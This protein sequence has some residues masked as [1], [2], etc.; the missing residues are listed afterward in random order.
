MMYLIMLGALVAAL[1][2]AY[3]KG[4]ADGAGGQKATDDA[5]IATAQAKVATT[6]A[7]NETLKADLTGI[8]TA[9]GKCSASVDAIAKAQAGIGPAVTVAIKASEARSRE[10][11]VDIAARAAATASASS[12]TPEQRCA[13]AQRILGDLSDRLHDREPPPTPAITEVPHA[14]APAAVTAP[15]TKPLPSAIRRPK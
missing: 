6:E 10:L 3:G 7:A 1:L 4:H 14:P 8:R 15:S 9:A 12:R 13:N 2:G 11:A 5:K